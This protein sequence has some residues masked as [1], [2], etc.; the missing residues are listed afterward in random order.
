MLFFEDAERAATKASTIGRMLGTQWRTVL[1]RVVDICWDI[2][3]WLGRHDIHVYSVLQVHKGLLSQRWGWCWRGSTFCR[4]GA[5]FLGSY[6]VQESWAF[7][8]HSDINRKKPMVGCFT[9]TMNIEIWVVYDVWVI[10]FLF[11]KDFADWPTNVVVV[12]RG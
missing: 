1:P 9:Y 8:L 2:W 10:V 3:D 11:N 5:G 12:S 4:F 7:V 6:L